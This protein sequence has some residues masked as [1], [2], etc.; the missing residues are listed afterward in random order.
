MLKIRKLDKRQQ[1][2]NSAQVLICGIMIAFIYN[3]SLNKIQ[4]NGR[5]DQGAVTGDAA[6][7]YPFYGVQKG[8]NREKCPFLL[9]ISFLQV[10]FVHIL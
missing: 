7:P 4:R 2:T 9:V 1:I 10:N 6:Q 5:G 8:A 3:Q